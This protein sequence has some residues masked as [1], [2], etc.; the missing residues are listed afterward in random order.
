[1]I[2]NIFLYKIFAVQVFNATFDSISKAYPD[3]NNDKSNNS[4]ITI[5]L[6]TVWQ[7]FETQHWTDTILFKCD[8]NA[9]RK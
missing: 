4:D 8:K 3:N 9:D 7:N 2:V 1:M 6:Y 5:L